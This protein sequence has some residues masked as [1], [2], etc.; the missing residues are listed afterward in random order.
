MY[1]RV[2]LSVEKFL[3]HWEG[4]D[5]GDDGVDGEDDVDYDDCVLFVVACCYCLVSLKATK[6][7]S[8]MMVSIRD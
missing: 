6:K 2:S 5:D 7:L 8:S 1:L 4:N 3:L